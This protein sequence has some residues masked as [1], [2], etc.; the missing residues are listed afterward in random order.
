MD[1]D[2]TPECGMELDEAEKEQLER[3]LKDVANGDEEE[4]RICSEW[5]ESKTDSMKS[6]LVAAERVISSTPDPC[7]RIRMMFVLSDTFYR[8][9]LKWANFGQKVLDSDIPWVW[10]AVIRGQPLNNISYLRSLISTWETN[11]T[12][13]PRKI[14]GFLRSLDQEEQQ[15]IR[16]RQQED[17]NQNKRVVKADR[18]PGNGDEENQ[19]KRTKLMGGSVPPPSIP[20]GVRTPAMSSSSGGRVGVKVLP[21]KTLNTIAPTPPPSLDQ[22]VTA[23]WTGPS[24]FPPEMPPPAVDA[25][26]L[27]QK[28]RA[29]VFNL[30]IPELPSLTPPPVPFLNLLCDALSAVQSSLPWKPRPAATHHSSQRGDE[31]SSINNNY[32]T[33]NNNNNK[34]NNN[35]YFKPR[36]PT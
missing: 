34:D 11:N 5:L 20:V 36:F 10:S 16:I 19:I 32:N 6:V 27:P 31:Y 2:D 24:A 35:D 30:P 3:L 29:P 1:S 21:T 4:E 28:Q 22:S 17:V 7:C 33:N 13:H 8:H 25:G 14:S 15:A 26:S 18:Q 12:F 23:V 9:Q